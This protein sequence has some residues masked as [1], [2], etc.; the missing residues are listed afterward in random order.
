[1]IDQEFKENVLKTMKMGFNRLNELELKACLKMVK[2]KKEE[3]E[4][5]TKS[6]MVSNLIL[7]SSNHLDRTTKDVDM[8]DAKPE[9]LF[10]KL[11]MFCSGELKNELQT[12]TKEY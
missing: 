6:E 4:K 8:K 12:I 5:M 10:Y 9:P 3:I 11:A 7:L 1:M 2:M